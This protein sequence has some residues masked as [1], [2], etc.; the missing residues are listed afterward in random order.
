MLYMAAHHSL[1]KEQPH[2]TNAA[3]RADY[4]INVTLATRYHVG[5]TRD[6]IISVLKDMGVWEKC[7]KDFKRV[8]K[9]E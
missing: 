6:L 3:N 1:F 2:W 4:P 5:G 8:Y 9:P 7:N